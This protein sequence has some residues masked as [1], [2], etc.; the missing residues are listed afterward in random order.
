MERTE[1]STV[2]SPADREPARPVTAGQRITRV[3]VPPLAAGLIA[4]TWLTCRSTWLRREVVLDATARGQRFIMAFWHSRLYFMR[5]AHVRGRLV[6]MISSHQDGEVVARTMACFGHEAVR[7][8]STRGGGRALR[9]AVRVAREG[10][11]LAITPDGPRGPARVAKPGAVEL[12]RVTGLPILPISLAYSRSKVL[13]S[14][15]GFEVPLPFARVAFAYGDLTWC[16]SDAKPAERDAASSQLE[17][18][19]DALTDECRAE[20]GLPPWRAA[21]RLR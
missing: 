15:D 5:Y 6:A 13:R 2:S 1:G 9:D 19:L 7:G 4:A 18:T 14:W 21:D 3:V 10:A 16:G 20:V 17:S 8:S 11:D 12:A